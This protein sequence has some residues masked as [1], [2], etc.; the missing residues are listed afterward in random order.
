VISIGKISV[1]FM[2]SVLESIAYELILLAGNAA[3]DFSKLRISPKHIL[4]AIKFDEEFSALV[5]PS[6]VLS[7]SGVIE[8]LKLSEKLKEKLLGN[9][10]KKKI[11]SKKGKGKEVKE[12]KSSEENVSNKST[13]ND[14]NETS[15]NKTKNSNNNSENNTNNKTI[16][17]RKYR[18]K[19][20]VEYNTKGRNKN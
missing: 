20:A 11:S 15:D 19:K 5:N 8:T 10:T 3:I 7:E 14:S 2:A 16:H 1:V 18:K 13:D 6:S 9:S 17:D 4:Y 12:K